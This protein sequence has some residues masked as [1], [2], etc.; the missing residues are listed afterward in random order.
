MTILRIDH[1]QFNFVRNDHGQLTIVDSEHG[2]LTIVKINH[3]DGSKIDG[4][5][6]YRHKIVKK[7]QKTSKFSF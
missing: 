4:N 1:G 5:V 2:Q 3:V 7:R 6:K